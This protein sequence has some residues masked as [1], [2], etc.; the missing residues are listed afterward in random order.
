MDVSLIAKEKDRTLLR[1]KGVSPAYLNELRRAMMTEV[2]TLAI[3][4]VEFRKNS[5]GL[6]DEIIAHRLGLL[7]LKTDLK[8]YNLPSKCACKGA[9]CAQCQLKFT[10]KAKG[11]KMVYAS[12]L[13]SADPKVVPVFPETPIVELL[14]GQELELEATAVLGLGVEHSKWSPGLVYYKEFP[15][16]TIKKQPEN[17]QALAEQYPYALEFKGGKLAVKESALP[18]Y[19]VFE[20][21]ASASNGSIVVD[22]KDDFVFVIEPWGQLSVEEIVAEAVKAFD[23]QL[24]ELAA[25]VKG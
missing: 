21:I 24:S 1:V 12:D 7:P 5:S 20:E 23:E 19:D 25:L 16:V 18:L 15:H 11:P 3:E 10:L 4:V 9:G 6:Y 14:D 17:A 22:Y 2:P 13:K 8:S